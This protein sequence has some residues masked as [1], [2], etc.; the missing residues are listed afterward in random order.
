MRTVTRPTIPHRLAAEIE[1]SDAL[2]RWAPTIAER[3]DEIVDRWR[4]D[5]AAP[6]E[7]GGRTA[8]VAPARTAAGEHV[9]LK[10]GF[11]HVE[12]AFEA[13][14]LRA[15]DGEGAV[16]VLDSTTIGPEDGSVPAT[17]ALLLERCD[18]GTPLAAE[19]EEH[20]D[21]VITGL[22][23]R[24]WT[25]DVPVDTFP[26]LQSMC[27]QWADSFE[28][29]DPKR[30]VDL[31]PGLARAGIALLRDLPGTAPRP[32]LLCTDL[33][34]ENVLA[35]QREPWLVV[36]P[37]PHVG[38]PT[39]DVIQHLLNCPTRLRADPDG[40]CRRVAEL[41]GLDAERVR[42]WLFARC[43][44]QSR[45]WPELAPLVPRLAP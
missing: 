14:G 42:T 5:V 24:L 6:Y 13:A 34:A 10:L 1:R 30:P 11:A 26:T 39:Y 3:L 38:D 2:A 44:Q 23:R 41:A 28:R 4:L 21:E 15:W 12:G 40:L 18:P 33:H 7:P 35:A 36:D 31:D 8:W 22:L 32:V 16:R 29:P 17:V 19:D 9:V 25:A 43:V 27:D 37:K 45:R 20:Q